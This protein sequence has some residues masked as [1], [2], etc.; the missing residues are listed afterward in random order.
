MHRHVDEP[1]AGR[2]GVHEDEEADDDAVISAESYI[3]L[4]EISQQSA[5]Q[6][7]GG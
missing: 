3:P 5:G 2:T 7:D 6:R 4:P 1:P